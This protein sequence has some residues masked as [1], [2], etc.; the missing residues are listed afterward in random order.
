MIHYGS[1]GLHI[2]PSRP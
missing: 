2:V 1:K